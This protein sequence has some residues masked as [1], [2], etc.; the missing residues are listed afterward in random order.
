M[1]ETTASSS[2]SAKYLIGD[3][4]LKLWEY[5]ARSPAVES[6]SE[7]MDSEDSP[8]ELD[9]LNSSGGF[10]VVGSDKLSVSY[11]NVNLHG[12]DVGVVQAN[13]PAPSKRLVYYFEMYVKNAGARGHVSIGFTT[14]GF[15]LR[16]QPG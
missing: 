14:S 3:Y 9:T 10:S 11:P 16:R 1:S 4:F 15:K 6:E 2:A 13:H 8:S 12:H 5:S 7:E